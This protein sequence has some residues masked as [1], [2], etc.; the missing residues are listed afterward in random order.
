MISKLQIGNIDFEDYMAY[1]V[2]SNIFSRPKRDVEVVTVPGRNGDLVYDNK[3]YNNQSITYNVIIMDDFAD[4]FDNLSNDVMALVGYQ[5]IYDTAHPNEYRIGYVEEDLNPITLPY[6]KTGKCEL[7]MNCKPQR[8]LLSGETEVEYTGDGTI[9]NPTNFDAN[10]VIR[11]YGYGTLGIGATS[12]IVSQNSFPYIDIDSETQD[13][14]YQGA[15]ANEYVQFVDDMKPTLSAGANG[16]DIDSHMSK[17]VI[18]PRW[19]VL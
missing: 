9:T 5:R 18:Q 3:R 7:I 14:E 17:V 4:N 2:P 8:Y 1:V 13:A 15:N 6:F 19:W 10:P 12:I 11:V 16:I